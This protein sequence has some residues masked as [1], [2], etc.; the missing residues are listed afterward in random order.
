VP[1]AHVSGQ[2]VVPAAVSL[3]GFTAGVLTRAAP[4]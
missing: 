1:A 3:D 4:P 2:T